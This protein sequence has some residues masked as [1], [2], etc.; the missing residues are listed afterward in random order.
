MPHDR[1]LQGARLTSGSLCSR[2]RAAADVG[3]TTRVRPH[4]RARGRRVPTSS[5]LGAR[6]A[7]PSRPRGRHPSA[8][9]PPVPRRAAVQTRLQEQRLGAHTRRVA[10]SP[11]AVHAPC[12]E[13]VGEGSGDRSGQSRSLR[14]PG[15]Q[16]TAPPL[17]AKQQQLPWSSTLLPAAW[18]PHTRSASNR[19]LPSSHNQ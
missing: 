19:S 18:A 2:Q 13:G 5:I 17:R 4:H 12:G 14:A 6:N 11:Y 16:P 15:P 7:A 9:S 3:W 10:R 1:G 8:C